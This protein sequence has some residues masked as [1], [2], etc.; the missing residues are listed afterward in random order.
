MGLDRSPPATA[1]A[2]SAARVGSPPSWR[3][4][5]R[6]MKVASP[7]PSS[8]ATT[9]RP[10]MMAA[11]SEMSAASACW[12]SRPSLTTC[13]LALMYWAQPDSSQAGVEVGDRGLG[14]VGV[15]GTRHQ[16][17]GGERDAGEGLHEGLRGLRMG[18]QMDLRPLLSA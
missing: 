17:G 8:S 13:S 10:A 4:R 18:S 9:M 11:P 14:F 2:T 5:L 3:I 15:G 16:N 7:A 1:R 6:V 12:P